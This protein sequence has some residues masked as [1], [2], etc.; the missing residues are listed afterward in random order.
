MSSGRP[1][2]P[3]SSA[4]RSRTASRVPPNTMNPPTPA[5]RAASILGRSR[6]NPSASERQRSAGNTSRASEEV[7]AG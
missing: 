5:A 3:R 2:R 7:T 4:A 6:R 1:A